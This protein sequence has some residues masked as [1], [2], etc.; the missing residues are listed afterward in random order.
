M[1]KSKRYTE[2]QDMAEDRR[3]GIKQ[4]SKKDVELDKKRGLGKKH[5]DKYH[6]GRTVMSSLL[7]AICLIAPKAHAA[8]CTFTQEPWTDNGAGGFVGIRVSQSCPA[9]VT[10]DAIFVVNHGRPTVTAVPGG[11][12]TITVQYTTST[13]AQINA[14]TAN[15]V[16]WPDGTAGSVSATTS[17]VPLGQITA[18]RQLPVTATG[19][20]EVA[21]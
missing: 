21:Q 13:I 20:L 15:W 2:D 4:G 9:G 10:G 17:D 14:S 8:A 6:V 16:A 3:R 7:L 5:R 11:G 1:S 18:I 12:G 19:V